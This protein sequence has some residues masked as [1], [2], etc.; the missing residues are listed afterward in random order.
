MRP[1]SIFGGGVGLV[2]VAMLAAGHFVPAL[3]AGVFAALIFASRERSP[4]GRRYDSN[5][6]HDVSGTGS[7]SS[8]SNDCRDDSSRDASD[9]CDD[10][11]SDSDSSNDCDA[12]GDSGGDSGGGDGGGGD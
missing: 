8:S 11:G 2:S 1:A 3:A 7:T 4:G 12:G 6:D 10:S 9:R 5:G